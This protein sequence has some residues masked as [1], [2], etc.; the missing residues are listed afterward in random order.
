MQVE[1]GRLNQEIQDAK[2]MK[3]QV[4]GMFDDGIIRQNPTGQFEAVLDPAEQ[5]SIRSN[6][7]DPSKRRPL[8]ETDIDHINADL[9]GME[10]DDI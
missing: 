5:E 9:D 7:A 4:Q 6:R 8:G 10:E 2:D 1:M 3:T